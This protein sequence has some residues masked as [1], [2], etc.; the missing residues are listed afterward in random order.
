M[1]LIWRFKKKLKKKQPRRQDLFSKKERE[2]GT[3][4]VLKQKNWPAMITLESWKNAADD[5]TNDKSF[6]QKKPFFVSHYSTTISIAPHTTSFGGNPLLT[7][8]TNTQASRYD[9]YYIHNRKLRIVWFLW[10]YATNI[11]VYKLFYWCVSKRLIYS[12]RLQERFRELTRLKFRKAPTA[13][14][15]HCNICN[16]CLICCE[17][18][19]SFLILFI[20]NTN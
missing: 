15:P 19:S 4:F 11:L 17:T 10:K 20:L 7:H 18:V 16:D 5:T 1:Q 2:A 3:A 8:W 13:Q 9:H 6:F 12:A 14:N